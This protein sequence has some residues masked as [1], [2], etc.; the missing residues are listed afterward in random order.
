MWG[1][2]MLPSK[3]LY[4]GYIC[5][6]GTRAKKVGNPCLNYKQ[7]LLALEFSD[8]QYSPKNIHSHLPKWPFSEKC[9]TRRADNRQTVLLGLA[10]HTDIGQTVLLGL[11]RHTDIGQ[12]VL[13]GLASLN[14]CE[15]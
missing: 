3:Q 6:R 5:L 13:R 4:L 8:C 9:K 14:S 1:C 2:K 10:R 11:A 15:Y 12:T 7:W